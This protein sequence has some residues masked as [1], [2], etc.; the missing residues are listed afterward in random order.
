MAQVYNN[1]LFFDNT[2]RH[3]MLCDLYVKQSHMDPSHFN[4]IYWLVEHRIFKMDID[5]YWQLL[6]NVIECT[7]L[8]VPSP[9]AEKNANTAFLHLIK[10][11]SLDEVGQCHFLQ[12]YRTSS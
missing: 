12:Y 10:F 8:L 5:A 3:Q 1:K 2:V 11:L 7:T 9:T 6:Q 4:L